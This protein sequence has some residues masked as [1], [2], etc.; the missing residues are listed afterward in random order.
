MLD[1]ALDHELSRPSG[2]LSPIGEE[3]WGEGGTVHAK[4][5]RIPRLS[6]HTAEGE[7]TSFGLR[8]GVLAPLRLKSHAYVI[9][10]SK[11]LISCLSSP[12]M[13]CLARYTRP[14]LTP[15]VRATSRT[16]HCLST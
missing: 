9:V 12:E 2:T 13:R 16:G 6:H 3:G 7:T 10:F 4:L 14:T 5:S 8:L 11:R 1:R 15:S